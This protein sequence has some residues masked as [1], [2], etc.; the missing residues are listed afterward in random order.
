MAAIWARRRDE[1]LAAVEVLEDA[2][3]EGL[4]GELDDTLRKAACRQAHKLAGSAGTFGFMAAGEMARDLE[5]V[6]GEPGDLAVDRFPRLADLVLSLRRALEEAP[7]DPAP[8]VAPAATI[9]VLVIGSDRE[10]MQ[11]IADEAAQRGLAAGVAVSPAEGHEVLGRQR[12]SIVV[13]DPVLP[14]GI[15][16]ARAFL[17]EASTSAWVLVLT[18]PAGELDRVEV[19]RRGG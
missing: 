19:A 2:V 3:L 14:G 1:V 7:A 12:P 5:G 13:L 11:R 16:A 6:L 8:A 18:D 4:A 9:D 10:R 15:E 17:S